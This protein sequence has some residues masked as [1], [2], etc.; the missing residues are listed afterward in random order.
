MA[1][2]ELIIPVGALIVVTVI[3]MRRI[4]ALEDGIRELQRRLA[5]QD[6]R[7]AALTQRVWQLETADSGAV[8]SAPPATPQAVSPTSAEPVPVEVVTPAPAETAPARPRRDDWEAVVG[9]NW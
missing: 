6:A 9:A 4:A 8:Q 3:L 1:A 7:S 5:D 2:V